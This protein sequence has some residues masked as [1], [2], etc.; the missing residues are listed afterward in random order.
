MAAP[1]ALIAT[2]KS[3]WGIW[4]VMYAESMLWA[5]G[6]KEALKFSVHHITG[7]FLMCVYH[8]FIFVGLGIVNIGMLYRPA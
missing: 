2:D 3:E 7:F 6:I 4:A 8:M 1:L 5:N